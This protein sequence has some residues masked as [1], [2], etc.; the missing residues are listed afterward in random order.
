LLR[1]IQHMRPKPTANSASKE[2]TKTDKLA[3]QF[4]GIA[5]PN[6]GPFSGNDD[7]VKEKKK[8]KKKESEADIVDD[9]MAALEALA[10]SQMM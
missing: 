7:E 10:P 1:I 5:L 8:K 2:E 6:D 9:A 4:P 3:K